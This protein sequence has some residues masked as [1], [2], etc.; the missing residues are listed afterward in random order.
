MSILKLLQLSCIV[1][2]LPLTAVA[3][4]Y[5]REFPAKPLTIDLTFLKLTP[6]NAKKAAISAMLRRNWDIETMY[7][8]EIIGSQSG[9]KASIRIILTEKAIVSFV[10]GYGLAD[11]AWLRNLKKDFLYEVI[12]C[13]EN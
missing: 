7:S 13:S 5:D 12:R 10:K 2:F 11:N 3:D 1:L 8:N 4:S 6:E 9:Y